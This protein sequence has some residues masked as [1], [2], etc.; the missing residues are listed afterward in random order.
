MYL[1]QIYQYTVHFLAIL[2]VNAVTRSFQKN[3][4]QIF[5][6]WLYFDPKH[7]KGQRKKSF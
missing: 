2:L 4:L 5:F 1:Y 6:H 3:Y 7:I